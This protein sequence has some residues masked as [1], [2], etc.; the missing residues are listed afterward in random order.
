M[1]TF[2]EYCQK[3]FGEKLYKISLNAGFTCPNR[4][5]TKGERGCI[6]CSEGGSGDFAASSKLSI[7]EQIDEAKKKVANK[8]KGSRYIAYFQAFTNTYAAAPYLEKLYREVIE[9]EDIAAISIATRPDCLAKDII[10]VI[11]RV[12]KIKPVI[13]ELGLQS[14]KPETIEYIRRA[15]ANEEYIEAVNNLNKIGVHTVTHVILGLPKETKEDMIS[16]VKFAVDAGTKGIKLQLLHVLKGTD[17]AK[18]YEE[19]KFEVLSLDEYIA[20]LKDCVSILPRDMVIHRL[21]GDGPKSLLI[22]PK[23]SGDKKM[24]LNRIN[25]DVV[26]C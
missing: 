4:D 22:A 13:V 20:I 25:K 2:N 11:E 1:L 8:Y 21:T 17:L 24:V 14:S 6:F 16:T 18:D 23:W 3:T 15:Y 9:R 12:N 26:I 10:E 19:G 7:N 5:G